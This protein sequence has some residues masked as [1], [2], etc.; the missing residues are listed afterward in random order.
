MLAKKYRLTKDKDIQNVLKKGK[1]F[2]HPFFNLKILKNNLQNPRFCIVISTKISK[3]AVVRNK[4]KRQLRAIIYKNLAKIS[5]N[6]DLV[7]LTK[8]AVTIT[9]FEELEKA[10]VS[11]LS[12]VK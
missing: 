11:L 8:P 1:I 7:I 10:L 4:V 12:K 9:Q 3:K 5:Q 6:Y 2:Y